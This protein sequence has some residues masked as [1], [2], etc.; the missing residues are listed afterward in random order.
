MR[1][2]GKRGEEGGREIRTERRLSDKI[3]NVDQKF[4]HFNL[5]HM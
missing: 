4:S 3:K 1:K 2:V 5:E